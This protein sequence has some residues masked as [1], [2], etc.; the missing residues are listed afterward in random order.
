VARVKYAGNWDPEPGAWPRFARFFRRET[1]VGLDVKPT[2]LADLNPRAAGFAHW[3]GTAAY[4]PSD[5]EIDAIRRY[6][7]DGGVLLVEPTGGGGDFY[8][9]AQAAIRKAFPDAQPK[10]LSKMHPILTASGPAMEDLTKPRTRLFVRARGMGTGGRID[11]LPAGR[12]MVILS[13]LDLTTGLLGSNVWGVLGFEK[14]YAMKLAKNMILW[15]A[16]GMPD[17]P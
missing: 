5:A 3:T 6:V 9:S 1:E 10:L 12:G 16:T 4:T 13:P 7:T 14:D 15:S 2:A 11:A 17:E 8:A